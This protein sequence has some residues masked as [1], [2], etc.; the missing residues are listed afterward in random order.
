M[1][2][3]NLEGSREAVTTMIT[4]HGLQVVWAL[5]VLVVGWLTAKAIQRSVRR[6]GERMK[7]DPTLVV[8]RPFK[9]GDFIEAL[10]QA[11]AS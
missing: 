4:T 11:D 6:F 3:W 10:H 1:E 5:V 7:L 8:F 9:V 2:S